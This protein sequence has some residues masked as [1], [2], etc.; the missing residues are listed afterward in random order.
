MK[1]LKIF[2]MIIFISLLFP[3]KVK[4]AYYYTKIDNL[5]EAKTIAKKYNIKL[6]SYNNK[7]ASYSSNKVILNSNKNNELYM[8]Y[9]A[10]PCGDDYYYKEISFDNTY[11]S[12]ICGKGSVVAVIDTGCSQNY[13]DLK[14]NIIGC[15]NVVDDSWNT[16]D[17]ATHGTGVASV[18]AAEDN[19]KG[20]TGIAC[21]SKLY[22]IKCDDNDNRIYY[23]NVIKAIYKCIELGNVNVINMSLGGYYSSDL[24]KDALIEAKNHGILVVCAAGNDGS[25][26]VFYPAAYQI[27]LSVA[28]NKGNKLSNFSN[29]GINANILAPGENILCY[30]NK[31]EAIW[32]SGTSF[33]APMVS[34]AAALVYSQ[35]LNMPRTAATVD[36]VKNIILQNTD[37]KVYS[38]KK[39]SV[40][41]KLNLQNI[42]KTEYIS[43]P[44]NPKIIIK[45]NRQTKQQVIQIKTNKNIDVYYS[46]DNKNLN[47]KYT[48]SIH[49][50]KKGK[51]KVYFIAYKKNTKA[52]S[53]IIR[54]D[55]IVDNS[56]YSQKYLNSINL[57]Y[58][59]NKMKITISTS[60]KKIDLSRVKWISSKPKIAK[61]EKDGSIIIS[62]KAKKGT[63]VDITT[64]IGNIKK[65][66]TIKIG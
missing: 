41:G 25:G 52:S 7:I 23:S 2:L 57:K 27:G 31:D 18:I 56:V 1:Y 32:M 29:F 62:D 63:V 10:Y 54:E 43:S 17:T 45:E 61:V 38:N 39:G 53:N 47:N 48:S 28:S 44:K 37:Q 59:K 65:V 3:I 60:G 14:N 36:Y 13:F 4:S 64:K 24:L 12:D 5:T 33:S 34:G 21:E 50:D 11:R 66:I 42:F 35:N 8:D 22:I 9:E 51:H 40:K 26:K 46:I 20:I 16:K 58:N 6:E 30:F 55:I 15:Y 49:L 19:H